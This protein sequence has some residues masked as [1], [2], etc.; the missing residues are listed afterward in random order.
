MGVA[1]RVFRYRRFRPRMYPLV[2]QANARLHEYAVN[3]TRYRS[4][5]YPN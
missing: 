1:Y 5:D 3:I 4:E 2:E